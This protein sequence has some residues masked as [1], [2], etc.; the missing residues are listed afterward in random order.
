MTIQ[1]IIK[2]NDKMDNEKKLTDEQIEELEEIVM[3]SEFHLKKSIPTKR[4]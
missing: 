1:L 4:K 2:E 3:L